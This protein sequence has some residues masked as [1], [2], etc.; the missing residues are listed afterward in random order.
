[1][2]LKIN[3]PDFSKLNK[4]YEINYYSII[5]DNR[6][7]EVAGATISAGFP[8]FTEN[9]KSDPISIDKYLISHPE[10][11]YLIRVK[12]DSMSDAGILNNSFIIVD[13]SRTPKNNDIIVARLEDE[14]LVKRLIIENSQIIL[15]AENSNVNYKDIYIENPDIFEVWGIVTGVFF[16]I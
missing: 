13:T 11:T 5:I 3:K 1:M 8:A 16:K 4:N 12:G 7:T 15:K 14:F 2:D 6:E 10:S 9:F